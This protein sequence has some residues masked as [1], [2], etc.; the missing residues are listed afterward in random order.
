[1]IIN[2]IKK[3]GIWVIIATFGILSVLGLFYDYSLSTAG[4]EKVVMTAVLRMMND[5]SLRPNY[6]TFYHLPLAVYFYLPFFAIA[7][8]ILFVFKFQ[9]ISALKS[10]IILDHYK[11]LPVARFVTL[12]FSLATIYLV[13]KISE[14][15][16]KNRWI[17]LFS[18]YFTASST[19][20]I[21]MS[22]FARVW[23]PQ[24]A[25]IVFGLYIL[26]L[27]YEK[28]KPNVKDYI[29]VALVVS[30]SLGV[31]LIGSLIYVPFIVIHGFKN[32]GRG[33]LKTYIFN[34]FFWMTNAIMVVCMLLIFYLNPYGFLN[35]GRVII[36]ALLSSTP[37]GETIY[38][39]DVLKK[40]ELSD[41]F[42]RKIT[43]YAE[44]LVAYDAALTLIALA[45]L[46]VLF[47][48]RRDI[49]YILSSFIVAYY[50]LISFFGS[51]PR[52]I[53]PLIPFLA[54]VAGYGV[55][56]AL[57]RVGKKTQVALIAAIVVLTLL[58]S[59]ALTR[60]FSMPST[61]ALAT[62][63]IYKNIPQGVALVDTDSYLE[64]NGNKQT[65]EDSKEFTTFFTVKQAYLLSLAEKEYP[66]PNYYVYLAPH[67]QEIPSVL[68][69]KR[70][71]YLVI[72]WWNRDDFAKKLD[73]VRSLMPHTIT[74][75]KRFGGVGEESSAAIDLANDTKWPFPY[76]FS[77]SRTGPIVDIYELVN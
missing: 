43:Y 62:E 56:C 44:T 49:F 71:N 30:L 12:L 13:Y 36:P 42:S 19:M 34:R 38:G 28:L 73:S 14:K 5:Y 74:L 48:R 40:M 67:F 15:I 3:Y 2:L 60:L 21:Y 4:D 11:L 7:L 32:K 64:L 41:P 61:R 37:A 57:G 22:H 65:M 59:L 29:V 33:F 52:Y 69:K 27:F 10:F 47:M 63:W 31:H 35:Y 9:D 58:P 66:A 18:A 23:M 68:Q 70:F 55:Y 51:T 25:V 75:V 8:V 54:L 50:V 77:M 16:F 6:P 46:A 76:L 1:M 45:S 72:S 39:S 17:S 24:I 20:F 53:S 26:I